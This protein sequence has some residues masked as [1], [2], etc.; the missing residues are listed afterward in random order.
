MKSSDRFPFAPGVIV[1][2]PADRAIKWTG[3]LAGCV[4][5]ACVIAAIYFR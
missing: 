1:G 3:R 5:L 4:A 2:G